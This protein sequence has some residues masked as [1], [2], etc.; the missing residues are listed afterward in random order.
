MTLFRNRSRARL[1]LGV[2]AS[3]AMCGNSLG[4]LN[5]QASRFSGPF[6]GDK[7]LPRPKGTYG[8]V[9]LGTQR[10]VMRDGTELATDIYLPDRPG[11]QPLILMRTPYDRASFSP[12]RSLQGSVGAFV[13]HGYAVAVQDVRGKFGSDGTFVPSL[14]DDIDSYDTMSWIVKQPWSDGKIGTYGCS[15]LGEAQV[16]A[17]RLRH[18][19]WKAAIPMASTGASGGA[20]GRNLPFAFWNGGAFEL[21]SGAGWFAQFGRKVP[22]RSDGKPGYKGEVWRT[23]QHLPVN[24]AL[25][26]PAIPASDYRDFIEHPPGDP[27][28]AKFPYL[29]EGDAVAVPALFIDSWYDYAPAVAFSQ[30]AYFQR[31]SGKFG[32]AHRIVIDPSTHCDQ[33]FQGNPTVVGDRTVGDARFDFWQLYFTWFDH[34]LRGEDTGAERMPL[35]QYYNMGENRW[36]DASAWPVPGSREISYYLGSRRGAQSRAGDGVLQAQPQRGGRTDRFVYD[37][38]APVPSIGGPLCCLPTSDG[39]SPAGS[40]DQTAVEDRRDVLVYST[41]PLKRAVD[42]TGPIRAELFVSSDAPDT[43]F[44]AKLVDVDA[45]GRAWNIV[46]GITRMRWRCGYARQ[47]PRLMP[48]KVYKVS[49]DLQATSNRFLAGHRIR[50]EISS[51]NFPRFDRNLNTGGPN[52]S[53][54]KPRIA[55]NAVH[56][57]VRYPSRVILPVVGPR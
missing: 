29:K 18:P 40:F 48:G 8:I 53:E 5:A 34:W 47:A 39:R 42:V 24:A 51:S 1:A 21:A 15:Y 10:I 52:V 6:A 38:A 14:T 45:E 55:H 9:R 50:L 20:A 12:E 2:A 27:F 32:A 22:E 4:P 36:R 19:A 31:H 56:L 26:D 16:I 49:I 46:E 57:D 30:L 3:I 11:P 7:P 33:H 54:A 23:M 28:W 41:A 37:P 17:S 35:V 13:G 43:D 25:D 44:T